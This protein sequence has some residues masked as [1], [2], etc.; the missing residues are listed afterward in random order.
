MVILAILF[1]GKYLSLIT[2]TREC[3][4]IPNKYA[5]SK[6]FKLSKKPTV[7]LSALASGD[8]NL[9]SNETGERT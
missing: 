6:N 9:M 2:S 1:F 5:T 7:Y 8:T 4:F 3:V